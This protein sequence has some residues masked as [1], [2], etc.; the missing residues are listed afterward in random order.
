MEVKT[1]DLNADLGEGFPWDA[2]LL[3]LVSSASVSC[4]AHA[5]DRETILTTLREARRRGVVVGAHPGFA[6]CE[7]FGRR[8]RAAT[9]A[10]IAELVLA[11]TDFLKTLAETE[12][13]VVRFVKPHGALY[14]QAQREDGIAAGVIAAV[15]S[16]GLPI[17]GLPGSRV[18]HHARI[19]GVRFVREG[20]ADRR[21]DA[22]DR[23][24]PR[25]QPDA[26][27]HVPS[28]IERQAIAL[29]TSGIETLCVHGDNP[30]SVEL[31]RLVRSTMSREQVR[32]ESFL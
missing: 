32:L 10:E 27:L 21:Y 18:E 31:A 16:L 5:G 25:G 24:V 17:L 12:D 28:E 22:S 23:L 30:D 2:A 9:L 13:V 14:N 1:I 8:E 11:Q 7:G 15:K 26:I 4:G 3:E 6:D 19:A 29:Q 20:F